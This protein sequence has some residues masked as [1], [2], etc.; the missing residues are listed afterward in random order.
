[1][2]NNPYHLSLQ[3]NCSENWAQMSPQE[4]GRYCQQC[5]KVVT[6]FT[7]MSDEELLRVL[8]SPRQQP[9]CGRFNH[10]QINKTYI[11][12]GRPV[13]SSHPL[14]R[15]VLASLFILHL[16][17]YA[18][19]PSTN[20]NQLYTKTKTLHP[21]SPDSVSI[22]GKVFKRN[23]AQALRA[24]IKVY[25]HNTNNELLIPSQC[26]SNGHYRLTLPTKNLPRFVRLVFSLEG[27]EERSVIVDASAKQKHLAVS[28]QQRLEAT[29]KEVEV[30]VKQL[31]TVEQ[32]YSIQETHQFMGI[33][34]QYDEIR[35][36]RYNRVNYFFRKLKFRIK[37]WFHPKDSH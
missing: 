29:L 30:V 11:P 15:S 8:S 31:P 21:N 10:N 27:F 19:T 2:P 22:Y 7:H 9:I 14:L 1:M 20:N 5:Q 35:V 17:S 16:P 18:Q 13:T 12:S 24:T 34:V 37:N 32:S 25:A 28:L 26:D 6:D 36:S 3:F 23:S 4:Q 33:P